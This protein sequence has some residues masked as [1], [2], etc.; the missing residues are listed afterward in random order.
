MKCLPDILLW[1]FETESDV[2]NINTHT[3]R[4][5]SW[6]WASQNWHGSLIH[7]HCKQSIAKVHSVLCEPSG[8]DPTGE[9]AFAHLTLTAHLVSACL[10][11]QGTEDALS[12]LIEISN[13][14]QIVRTE[15]RHIY[16][17]TNYFGLSDPRLAVGIPYLGIIIAQIG[18]TVQEV[19]L[20]KVFGIEGPIIRRDTSFL[21]LAKHPDNTERWLRIGVLVIMDIDEHLAIADVNAQ[22]EYK[23]GQWDKFDEKP[24]KKLKAALV[25]RTLQARDTF[26]LFDE[27]PM[28]NITIW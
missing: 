15:I 13:G 17:M 16:S 21:L 20:R 25:K 4:A 3:W 24:S 1:Y 28:Q 10:K 11:R 9:L 6:S 5:P 18:S 27:A 12:Y 19:G 2:L 26:R 7:L 22:G 14:H 23:V 8:A